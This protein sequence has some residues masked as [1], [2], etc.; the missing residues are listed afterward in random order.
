[1]SG[2]GAAF[3]V[4]SKAASASFNHRMLMRMAPMPH[5][6][7]G[8]LMR[9][10]RG[11]GA[12]SSVGAP[13]MAPWFQAGTQYASGAKSS[14]GAPFMA[15]WFQAGT[16]YASGAKFSVGAPFMAPWFQAGTQY[17]S[18]AKSPTGAPFMAPWLQA[19]D[20]FS[21]GKS[22]RLPHSPQE[23]SYS[24]ASRTPSAVNARIRTT[25]VTPEPQLA[26]MG[27]SSATPA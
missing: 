1:M 14:V 17:A 8:A 26:T 6:T 10:L 22:S 9:P 23:P 24:V 11:M 4:I 7:R 19:G 3:C 25:A 18:G 12:K 16:Q 13:F 5:V 21:I 2:A 20:Y 27:R 15:P